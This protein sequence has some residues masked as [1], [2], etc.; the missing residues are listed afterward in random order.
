MPRACGRLGEGRGEQQRPVEEREDSE[1]DGGERDGRRELVGA[2]AEHLAEQQ[3]VDLGRVFDAEAEKQRSEA[4]HEHERE[5][6]RDVVAP[7][8]AEES[9]PER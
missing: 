9:D 6:G 8:A 1:A 2:D 5:R 3:R 7:A 4:E